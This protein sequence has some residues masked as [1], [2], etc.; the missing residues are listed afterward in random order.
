MGDLYGLALRPQTEAIEDRLELAMPQEEITNTQDLLQ[1]VG[2][3][4]PISDKG[5]DIL[6]AM[7]DH[8]AKAYHHTALAAE[9]FT[10]LAHEC[11]TQQLMLVMQYG[12][13]PIIQVEGTI[14]SGQKVT[15][16]KGLLEDMA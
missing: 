2:N 13:R 4:E 10:Q 3:I 7:M 12:V 15:E 8:T 16:K 9:Q 14:G 6:I 5:K 1:M 11:L